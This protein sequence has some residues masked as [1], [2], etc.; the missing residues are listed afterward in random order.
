MCGPYPNA[1]TALVWAAPISLATTFGIAFAFF[2]SGYLDVSVPRV[3]SAQ[4]MYSSVS[5]WSS[6]SWVS[7]FGYHGIYACLRLPHAFRSLPRPSSALGALASALCSCSLDFLENDL[8]IIVDPETNCLIFL[9]GKLL[10]NLATGL[11]RLFLVF[12][13]MCGCQGACGISSAQ[14]RTLK[15]IQILRKTVISFFATHGCSFSNVLR[16]YRPMDEASDFSS[17]CSLERR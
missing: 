13:S 8:S 11:Q 14:G 1:I 7:P 10:P 15:T 3:P 16:R 4:T 12:L 9:S 6:T 5:N 17:A 2:S